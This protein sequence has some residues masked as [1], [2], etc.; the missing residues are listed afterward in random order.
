MGEGVGT[1]IIGRKEGKGGGKGKRTKER[2]K[3]CEG[4][5]NKVRESVIR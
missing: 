2:K 5:S 3:E 4:Q 1:S